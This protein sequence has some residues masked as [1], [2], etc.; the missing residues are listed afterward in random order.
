MSAQAFGIVCLLM[1]AIPVPILAW[2]DRA[3]RSGAKPGAE[4]R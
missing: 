1:F 3:P 4:Q 2:L